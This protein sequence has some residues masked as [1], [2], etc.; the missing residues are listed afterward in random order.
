MS[1]QFFR[2]VAFSGLWHST[3]ATLNAQREDGQKLLQSRMYKHWIDSANLPFAFPVHLML[4]ERDVLVVNVDPK[5]ERDLPQILISRPLL[6]KIDVEG[7][8]W[9]DVSEQVEHDKSKHMNQRT[10]CKS[11]M[12][13]ASKFGLTLTAPL[14][15]CAPVDTCPFPALP[16]A[17][18]VCVIDSG[19]VLP[20]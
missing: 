20:W 11:P 19:S 8:T 4:R 13:S 14:F 5:A 16:V 15:S 18:F 10:H 2:I 1:N 7:N 3:Y 9:K 6:K 17:L 12:Y